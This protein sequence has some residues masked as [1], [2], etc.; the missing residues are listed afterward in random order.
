MGMALEMHLCARQTPNDSVFEF[1]IFSIATEQQ[2]TSTLH[3]AGKYGWIAD[4]LQKPSDVGWNITTNE[5][6]ARARPIRAKSVE[7]LHNLHVSLDGATGTFKSVQSHLDDYFISPWVLDS[8][9][10][11]P[12]ASLAQENLSATYKL[13][14]VDNI[15]IPVEL[16]STISSGGDF[17][18]RTTSTHGFGSQSDI[19]VRLDEFTVLLTGLKYEVDELTTQIPPLESLFFTPVILPDISRL[20]STEALSLQRCLQLV[21]HKWPMCDIG[22]I[23]LR[24]G[25]VETIF[26]AL[27][28]PGERPRFRSLQISGHSPDLVSERVRVVEQLD[29][30]TKFHV[31]FVDG[32]SSLNELRG[33]LLSKGLVCVRSDAHS[34]KS[35]L[36]SS[37]TKVCDINENGLGLWTLWRVD[38]KMTATHPHRN[39]KVFVSPY[40][41]ISSITR[42]PHAEYVPLLSSSTVRE[43]GRSKRTFE[44]VVIDSLEKSIITSWTGQELLP[45]L[46]GILDS[47][48]SV[49]WVTQ[50]RPKNPYNNITGN[51]LRTVQSEQP[52]IKV[53]WLVLNG[54]YP[55][56]VL[57]EAI[58]SAYDGLQSGENEVCLEFKDSRFSILRYLPDDELSASMGLT[59]PRYLTDGVVDRDYRISLLKRGESVIKAYNRECFQTLDDRLVDVKVEASIIDVDDL[60]AI[61]G[62]STQRCPGR[63]FAGRVMYS[64]S[65]AFPLDSRIV[66]WCSAAH[67]NILR[68]PMNQIWLCREGNSAATSAASL[69]AISTALSVLDGNARARHGDTIRFCIGGVLGE[70]IEACCDDF[71]VTIL[72][73]VA[74]VE[75]DYVVKIDIFG[76]LL[77][78][79]SPIDIDKYLHSE[80]GMRLVTQAWKESQMLETPL[81]LF[82][83]ADHQQ[84]FEAAKTNPCATVLL[85]D[86]PE[87]IPRSVAVYHSPTTLFSNGGAYIIIGGLGGLGRYI[88]TW[89]A[90]H[91]AENLIVISRNGINSPEARE[92]YNDINT[93]SATLEVLQAD[94]CNRTAMTAALAHVRKT[95]PIKGVI[96]MAMLLGDAPLAEMQAWQWD[97]ALRLKMESSWILHEETIDDPLEFFI[98]FSSIASVLGNRNQAGYNI[99]NTFLNSLAEYRRSLGRTAVSVALG[100]MGKCH[101]PLS[102]LWIAFLMFG[103]PQPTLAFSMP[104]MTPRSF[105][106]SLAVA[107]PP[108]INTTSPALSKPPS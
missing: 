78:N 36:A 69:A 59:S 35:E 50:Q 21:T 41:E 103:I 81:R 62:S 67:R 44:A 88:C 55:G 6:L 43:S 51:L 34:A 72:D 13:L 82:N 65:Q 92:T 14:S 93:S 75:A 98:L 60:T 24:S 99:G 49:L 70:A 23:G 27:E 66:G 52:S 28:H 54:A 94:A 22:V 1:E 8:L 80:R 68:V 30:N 97:R 105:T 107:S 100:A 56:C 85:H 102:L 20:A 33:S 48:S 5:F 64:P 10:Q 18:V 40:Q 11:L 95:S 37:F 2:E 39:I 101:L 84:A 31:M 42:L 73:P 4:S 26:R 74:C 9:L 90:S 17:A 16:F 32:Q 63:F 79:G 29:A 53:T 106:P 86:H 46:Q 71:G 58:A 38:Q 96:N 12:P 87:K 108:C 57:Q 77:V 15:E 104:S 47:A 19:E 76:G 91:G 3:C 61:Y 83:I 7:G 45:W 25:D 89:M